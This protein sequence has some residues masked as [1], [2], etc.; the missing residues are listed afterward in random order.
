MI[1][2]KIKLDELPVDQLVARF[3][4]ITVAQDDALLG[5]ELAKIRRLYDR[6]IEVLD[7]LKGR[8]GDQRDA[9]MKLYEYPNMQV[10]LQAATF[11]LAVRHWRR[12]RS[13]NRLQLRTGFRRLAMQECPC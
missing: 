8:P 5:H 4:A 10:Q 11:T 2:R 1:F 6:M 9:L 13:W 3:A 7:E 12:A